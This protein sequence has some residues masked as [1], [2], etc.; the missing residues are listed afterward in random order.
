MASKLKDPKEKGLEIS[1]RGLESTVG[2]GN[3]SLVSTIKPLLI[4]PTIIISKSVEREA[5]V[6][7]V[8][9]NVMDIF[10]A[11]YLQAFSY[12]AEIKDVVLKKDIQRLSSIDK[13]SPGMFESVSFEARGPK[14]N[15]PYVQNPKGEKHRTEIVGMS[16][17]EYKKQQKT[18]EDGYDQVYDNLVAKNRKSANVGK[19]QGKENQGKSET[20]TASAVAS[21]L[22]EK[23]LGGGRILELK[24]DGGNN[25]VITIP[26]MLRATTLIA[27]LNSVLYISGINE[28][29]ASLAYR[30]HDMK[31]G[32]ISFWRDFILASDIIRRKKAHLISETDGVSED[33]LARTN[34]VARDYTLKNKSSFGGLY[35]ILIISNTDEDAMTRVIRKKLTSDR[36]RNTLFRLNS[37]LMIAVVDTEWEQ[38][39]IY[40][41]EINNYITLSFNDLTSSKGNDNLKIKDILEAFLN[42]QAPR[43]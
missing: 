38:V 31:S 29:K 36:A 15:K 34:K 5:I 22:K 8:V 40:T 17:S 24:V 23:S 35:N 33:I 1:K 7:S 3:L 20:L 28:V 21:Q 2:K 6:P 16:R 14:K 11:Y 26:M 10:A 27:S 9:K 41:R 37:L 43:L 42:N 13:P 12:T 19:Q 39:N 18:G 32:K 4:E 25:K 30:W